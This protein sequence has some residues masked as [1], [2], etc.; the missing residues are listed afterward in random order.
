MK[1]KKGRKLR[2]SLLIESMM[3]VTVMAIV[4][5][6]LMPMVIQLS[7]TSDSAKIYTKMAVISD[8]VGQYLFRWAAFPP[9]KKPLPLSYYMEEEG[10]EFD[11]TGDKRINSMPWIQPLL[12]KDD[13]IE[14]E[15][16]VSITFWET[17]TRTQSAVVKVVVWYDENLDGVLNVGERQMKFSTTLS[18]SQTL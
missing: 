11:I 15:Y 4:S 2:G 16:K 17:A 8:Y 3:A 5:V 14:D 13:F 6:S 18:E 12:S 9:D 7:R 10:K 1:P